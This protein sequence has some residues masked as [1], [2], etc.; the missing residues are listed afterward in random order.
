FC[1]VKGSTAA[2]RHLDPE[3]WAE[4]INGA[5]E[6]LIAPVYRYEGTL[7]RLMGDAIL[8][9]FG[10]P[11]AHEDDPLRAVLA[12]LEILEGIRPYSE[13]V[14]RQWGFEFSVR[15]GINTG[16]VVVGE[17]GSDL[18]MEYSALGDAINVASLME[19]TAQPGTL[20]VSEQSYRHVAPLFE[21]EPPRAIPLKG[22]TEVVQAYRVVQRKAQPG[23]LRGIQGLDA[24]LVGRHRELEIIQDRLD[25]LQQGVGSLLFLVG[26]AGLGKSR[27][28]AETR[29][30]WLSDSPEMARRTWY[31]T[32]SLSYEMGHPYGLFQRLARHLAGTTEND[33]PER[34][35]EHLAEILQ[36]LS[37]EF[38]ERATSVFD[39]L[40]ATQSDGDGRPLEGEAFKRQLFDVM[41]VLWR[42]LAS[43]LPT[44]IVFDDLHW[45]DTASIA[46]L[47]HLLQ[48]TEQIPLLI[49]G[50]LRPDRTAPAWQVKQMAETDYFHRYRE[51]TLRPL[52]EAESDELVNR[53]L[54]VAD[55]PSQ[56]R[57]RILARTEGNPFF[58][59]EVV[60]VLIDS[61][62][63]ARDESGNHWITVDEPDAI[64][65][66][67]SLQ[68]LLI[69][70]IDR[71]EEE[72]RRTL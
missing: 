46:L 68:A 70:R 6:Y 11:I 44:I 8:A 48:L 69:S 21:F 53:L 18:R 24:A 39:T 27:L 50:A 51:V 17:V 60:R 58:V 72:A 55:L 40:F 30:R 45:A 63:M 56:L 20:Q 1:D 43:S 23:R 66:P 25:R 57:Q 28:I 62:A 37:P 35:R 67:D 12:G 36:S 32:A 52:S 7:A 71:L 65:I 15:V 31:E 64:E 22:T 33:P 54:I 5:F 59:E 61:G 26:E 34:T 38:R 19:E 47:Q 29:T 42:E 41:L 4:I 14:R 16:L 10:A 49:I 3:E 9:F 2:A 13:Q